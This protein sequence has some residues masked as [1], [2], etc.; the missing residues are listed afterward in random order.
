MDLPKIART[1]IC[2]VIFIALCCN[3]FATVGENDLRPIED[4]D[5]GIPFCSPE[6]AKKTNRIVLVSTLDGKVSALNMEDGG[7]EQWSVETGPGP[8]LSS[9]IH[10]LEL[11]NNGQWVRMIPSLSGGLYKMN[12]KSVEA[13]PITAETLLKSSFMYSNEIVISGGMETRTYGVDSATGKILYECSMGSCENQ[14]LPGQRPDSVGDVILIQRQTQTVRALDPRQ[15]NERWNFS[16]AQHEIKLSPDPDASCHD[17]TASKIDDVILKVIVPDGLVCALDATGTVIWKH[18][19]EYPVVSAWSVGQKGDVKFVDLFGGARTPEEKVYLPESPVLYVGMHNKQLY[20]QESVRLRNKVL[21]GVDRLKHHLITD[22]HLPSIPWRPVRAQNHILGIEGSSDPI[23]QITDEGESSDLQEVTGTSVLY[24]SEYVNG[25]GF[26]LYPSENDKLLRITEEE[27]NTSE[28]EKTQTKPNPVEGHHISA[29]ISEYAGTDDRTIEEEDESIEHFKEEVQQTVTVIGASFWYWWKE[30][31]LTSIISAIVVNL[32]IQRRLISFLYS[33]RLNETNEPNLQDEL[34]ASTSVTT[35]TTSTTGLTLPGVDFHSRYLTDFEPVRRLGK[36]GFGIVFQAKN[37]MDDCEYAVKRI[38]LPNKEEALERMKREVKALAKLDHQNIVRYFNSWVEEPPP[39]WQETADNLW[40]RGREDVASS[41][42]N[43]DL[44][45]VITP[46]DEQPSN[47]DFASPVRKRIV[48]SSLWDKA[49]TKLYQSESDDKEL[50][51][52]R[53]GDDVSD[54]FIVFENSKSKTNSKA[55]GLPSRSARQNSRTV[56]DS[57]GAD[58]RDTDVTD[59]SKSACERRHK[60]PVSLNVGSSGSLSP[61]P[62]L[63]K[64]LYIQMQLCQRDS[65]KDWLICNRE[66]EKA[67]V[68]NIFDQIVSAVDYVHCQGLIHRDLKPSNIFFSYDGQIKVGDFGLVTTMADDDGIPEQRSP[69]FQNGTSGMGHTAHVG[70][71]LYMSPEQLE[72]KQYDYKVDIFSLGVILFELLT[73]FSTEMER[74][75]TLSGVRRLEFPKD[76][77]EQ[78]SEEAALLKQML[79]E[80]PNSRLTTIGVRSRKPLGQLCS[81]DL[82]PDCTQSS[83]WHYNLPPRTR[84]RPSTSE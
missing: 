61:T 75:K 51:L 56:D 52:P 20:I 23:L 47:A 6:T 55:S 1:L 10:N 73:A 39:G 11:S 66:R 4:K 41:D 49:K 14:T 83:E 42:V 18:K 2:V 65:L 7:S 60:R 44:T 8:M 33:N 80:D 35:T 36:G 37:K 58:C 54:S 46:T 50:V 28:T 31:T 30:V 19:F 32:I 40:F 9:S 3:C 45:G 63:R 5:L 12:G 72:G 21:E 78:H 74:A 48:L 69:V 53:P 59:V 71:Q 57:E 26:Y 84:L 27:W 22:D 43:I 62:R 24:A 79:C 67:K 17:R 25:Q 64:F 13:V 34:T 16:V 15:G 70:T 38:T 77:E 68:V 29:N 76:F 81:S 82:T